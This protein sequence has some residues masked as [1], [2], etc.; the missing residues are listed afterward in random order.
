MDYNKATVEKPVYCAAAAKCIYCG[1]ETKRT[2]EHVI[3]SFLEGGFIIPTASCKTCQDATSGF[4]TDLSRTL[5]LALRKRMGLKSRS[6]KEPGY[7]PPKFKLLQIVDGV[8]TEKEVEAEGMPPI[9]AT[10]VYDRCGLLTGKEP[11]SKVNVLATKSTQIPGT[12]GEPP[13]SGKFKTEVDPLN[14]LRLAAKIAH[15]L[16][17]FGMDDQPME[18]LLPS[19]IVEGHYAPFYVG[20]AENSEFARDNSRKSDG[21]LIGY[22]WVKLDADDTYRY[23]VL[24]IKLFSTWGGPTFEVV[25][26]RQTLPDLSPVKMYKSI[27]LPQ[28]PAEAVVREKVGI[29][30][31][32]TFYKRDSK[33]PSS[34]RS[35]ISDP[36]KFK[37]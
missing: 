31:D 15:G 27:K 26:A 6:E 37:D 28:K 20:S 29:I 18:R 1:S 19:V 9:F 17:Y 4:E 10:P 22:R 2:K 16:T 33:R 24:Y 34:P 35:M 3:P 23:L 21:H 12:S 14:L 5:F 30:I 7:T 32:V 8:E 11:T 25:T 36:I 13:S